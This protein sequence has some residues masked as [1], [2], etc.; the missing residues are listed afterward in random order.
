MKVNILKELVQVHLWWKDDNLNIQS[1]YY[2]LRKIMGIDSNKKFLLEAPI[3]EGDSSDEWLAANIEINKLYR[4]DVGCDKSSHVY[5]LIPENR[6]QIIMCY[7]KA[8]DY[9]LKQMK[10]SNA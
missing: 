1:E 7:E 4:L 3:D 5:L 2:Y 10:D 6:G 9:Y 8:V